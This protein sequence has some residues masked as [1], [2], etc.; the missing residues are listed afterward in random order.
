V[1]RDKHR[2]SGHELWSTDIEY[3][4]LWVYWQEVLNEPVKVFLIGRFLCRT[5][6]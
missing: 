6:T 1:G 3:E 2:V 4:L 5:V